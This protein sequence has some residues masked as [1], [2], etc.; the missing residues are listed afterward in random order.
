[1]AALGE[2]TAKA[3]HPAPRPP[4][5]RAASLC[6][7]IAALCAFVRPSSAS[8][9]IVSEA[10]VDAP[11]TAV[12]AAWTTTAGLRSW[13]APHADMDLRV[14]GLMRT[15]YGV[16]GTLGDPGTIVNRVLAYDP[17]RMLSL[18][19]VKAPESFPFRARIG[20]MWT[21]LYFLPTV[22]S[23]T[24]VRVVGL[25]FGTDD[26]SRRMKTFFE[27]GNAYTLDQLRTHFER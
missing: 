21:V 3:R 6:L 17:E 9:S 15:H 10:V 22:D 1:M 27:Q 11:V 24:T 13:L 25:G 26:E 14:D 8:D 20:E 19:V 2:A 23:R 12:W 7:C 16:E 18:Q 5:R 4:R